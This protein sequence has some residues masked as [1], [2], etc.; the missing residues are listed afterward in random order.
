MQPSITVTSLK[1]R[2]NDN[3]IFSEIS[4]EVKEGEIVAIFGPNGCGKSTILNILS[5]VIKKD[6]GNFS[7]KNFDLFR[8]SYIFQNYRES[9]LLWKNNYDNMAFPMK[10]QGWEEEEIKEKIKDISKTLGIA[11]DMKLFPYEMSGG[12]QQILAIMRAFTN[13]PRI[14][15]MDEPFSALDYENNLILRQKIQNYY[16]KHRPTM[17]IITH[18]IEEA[19]HLANKII[20][21]SKKPAR[22]LGT[23]SNSA[24]YPR[25]TEF[26]KSD[27]F[28]KTKNKVL[29]A[30]KKGADL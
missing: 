25:Y 23:I 14:I 20:V 15:F 7:I 18:D 28:R 17:L 26:L 5:D 4:F 2:F 9:L 21:L 6:G 16:I 24:P 27:I 19:V 1:K 11:L 10:L 3:D 13:N 30:F 8:F 12:Q 22:I 29:D